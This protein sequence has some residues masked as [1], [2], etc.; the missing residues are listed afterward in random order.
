MNLEG[1][2][3][4]GEILRSGVYALVHRGKVVYIGKSKVMLT[5][6][7]SHRSL[8][9]RKRSIGEWLAIKGILFDDVH[10]LPCRLEDIDELEREMIN[11]YRPKF[12][13]QLKE[14][15]RITTPVSLVVNGKTLTLNAPQTKSTFERRI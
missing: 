6:I 11:I 9:G 3:P 10:I 2:K 4:I 7:Y 5:R 12:N 13:V 8:W 1:F 15:H 14:P